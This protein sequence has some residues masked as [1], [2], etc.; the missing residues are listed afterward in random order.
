MRGINFVNN[1]ITTFSNEEMT[2]IKVVH[3][4]KLYN[5]VVESFLFWINLPFLNVI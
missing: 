3:L 4:E 5:F 2:R 1:I